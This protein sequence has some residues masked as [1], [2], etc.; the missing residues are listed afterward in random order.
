MKSFGLMMKSA[1]LVVVVGLV[2]GVVAYHVSA[3]PLTGDALLRVEARSAQGDHVNV[4][5]PLSLLNTVFE[6]MPKEVQELCA[7]MDLN[8]DRIVS[9]FAVM[10]GQDIV[11]VEGP[12]KVRVWITETTPETEDTLG[13]VKIHVVEGRENG[14]E[15]NVCIPRGFVQLIGGIVK[16][17]KL[18]DT[19]VELPE[20]IKK[21]HEMK[22]KNAQTEVKNES[23]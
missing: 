17:L 5:V 22:V 15:V 19:F 6:A 9:E 21:L 13:F 7:E 10:K 2:L 11:K 18:A 4:S 23:E 16:E 20:E 12:D 3:A 1:S 14:H 8:P